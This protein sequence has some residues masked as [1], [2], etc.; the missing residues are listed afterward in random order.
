MSFSPCF[1]A[2]HRIEVDSPQVMETGETLDYL[3]RYRIARVS[4]LVAALLAC[5]CID[6][7]LLV[8]VEPN[9]SGQIVDTRYLANPAAS[10][11]DRVVNGVADMA[12]PER[13]AAAGVAGKSP[14]PDEA[15]AR[16]QAALFGPGVALASFT[17][18]THPDDGARGVRAV[19]RFTD[20]RKVRINPATFKPAAAARFFPAA[21]SIKPGDVEPVTF[22]FAK[23]TLTVRMPPSG[24]E[25]ADLPGRTPR[26]QQADLQLAEGLAPALAGLRLRLAVQPPGSIRRTNATYVEAGSAAGRAV[27]LLDFDL[28][29]LLETPDG[30]RKLVALQNNQSFGTAAELLA[31]VPGLKVETKRNVTIEF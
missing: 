29:T 11:M 13:A 25:K 17:E 16:A 19:Y 21:D 1:G 27:M 7:T 30:L 26:Q 5:G 28:D 22:A 31:R 24:Q 14:L 8:K 2:T 4:G 15:T 9:G 23:R 10:L 18:L 3:P 6:G 20:I 12:G